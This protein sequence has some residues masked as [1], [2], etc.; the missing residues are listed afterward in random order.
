VYRFDLH[1]KTTSKTPALIIDIEDLK[2][3]RGYSSGMKWFSR[4]IGML[5]PRKREVDFR[6]SGIAVHPKTKDFYLISSADKM[7]IVLNREGDIVAVEKL[8]EK[9]FKQPEGICF[10]PEGDLFISNE[11]NGGRAN[12]VRFDYKQ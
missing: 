11:K 7:L 8:N 5:D 1:T 10:D 2:N 12:I 6:P 4:L 3:S 9:I